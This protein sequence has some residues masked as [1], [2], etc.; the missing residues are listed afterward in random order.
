G[1]K[2]EGEYQADDKQEVI[3][4]LRAE[5]SYPL[6]IKENDKKNKDVLDIFN[7]VKMKDISLFCRQ[8]YAMLNAGVT[9][10]TSLEVLESQTE[11]KKMKETIGNVSDDVQKGE[12]LTDAMKKYGDVFPDL[13]VNMIEVGEMSG[14]LDNIMAKMAD[15]YEREN[16]IRNKVKGAMVYPAILSIVTI[17][18]VIF[19]LT[20]VLPTF[21]DM[22]T[23]SGVVLPLP[24]RILLT[25]S[26]LLKNYWYLFIIILSGL[27]LLFRRYKKSEVG[28]KNIDKIKF[29]IPIYKTLIRDMMTTRFSRTLAIM[30]TS[31]IP[32]MD[33]LDI[34]SRVVG[35]KVV[36]E[37][38]SDT[39]DKMRQGSDLSTPIKDIKIFPPMLI[40]MIKIGE[41]SGA[42]DTILDKAADY[43]DEELETSTKKLTT[44]IEPIMIVIMAI[45]VGFIVLSIALPMFDMVNT[46]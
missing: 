10:N 39:M 3:S 26:S 11:N 42:L 32:L 8:I 22:F 7:K 29:K 4:M 12:T 27:F 1:D 5:N 35:N 30:I 16:K 43:Y 38:I 6:E 34:V 9:V 25:I 18:V 44:M 21:V 33:A 40:S 17:F 19:L 20:A 24:T 28:K 31:G 2:I 36:K 14:N 46:I 15:Y 45:I 41:E 13:L 23:G 37:G